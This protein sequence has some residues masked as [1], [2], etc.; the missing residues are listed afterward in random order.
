[1]RLAE[2][3]SDA[4]GRFRVG[5]RGRPRLSLW[6]RF[7]SEARLAL[8]PALDLEDPQASYRPVAARPGGR[9]RPP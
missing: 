1:M 3:R 9:R 8:A 6:P 7:R 2:A 4:E 5:R